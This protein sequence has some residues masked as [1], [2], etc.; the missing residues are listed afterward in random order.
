MIYLLTIAFDGRPFCGF[1][2]QINGVSVQETLS[3]AAGRIFGDSCRITGCSRTDSGVHARDFKAALSVDDGAVSLSADRV[4]AAINTYLPDSVEVLSAAVMPDD[5]HVRYDV[6][7]KEYQYLILNTPVRDPFLVGRAWHYPRT[8][9][10]GVMDEAAGYLVGTHDFASFMAS[11]SDI[12][13]T[14]RTVFA[15]NVSRDG[16]VVR[17]TV[18]GNGFLYHMVRIIVGTLVGVSEGRFRP[19]DMS[20]L[21]EA[22]DR[23]AAG[24]TAPA[25]GLYLTR[26]SY[27]EKGGRSNGGKQ[28]ATDEK[29]S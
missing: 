3:Q 8:L 10:V 9:S 1:Q 14:V 12:R 27:S 2:K 28:R 5:F 20:A 26:V 11:G 17:V 6:S 22:K 21:L 29:T 4:P 19:S 15:C 18:S 25:C 13:D 24:R 16:P 23:N 7:E